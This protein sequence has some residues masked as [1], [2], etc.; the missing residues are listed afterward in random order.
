[1]KVHKQ[2]T[3]ESCEPHFDIILS[4]ASSW[5]YSYFGLLFSPSFTM[6]IRLIIIFPTTPT[7]PQDMATVVQLMGGKTTFVNRLDVFFENGFHDMGDEVR[8]RVFLMCV[9]NRGFT[10]LDSLVSCPLSSTTMRD[11]QTRLST[12]CSIYSTYV[13]FLSHQCVEVSVGLQK[14]CFSTR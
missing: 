2:Y 3:V 1:M 5:E 4:L 6:H 7:V 14:K 12:E 8:L 9:S 11:V 10:L 13:I